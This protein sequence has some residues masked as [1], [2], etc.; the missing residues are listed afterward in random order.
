MGTTTVDE[1]QE[2][3]SSKS[4]K[5]EI[6]DHDVAASGWIAEDHEDGGEESIE[7]SKKGKAIAKST[8]PSF[9]ITLMHGDM[10]VFYGDEF[11]VRPL[12]LV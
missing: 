11:E 7:I 5:N 1:S 4:P 6:V 8:K 3:E 12:D 2:A 9:V 10:I